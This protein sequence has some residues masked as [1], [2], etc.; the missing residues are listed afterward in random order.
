MPTIE[1]DTLNLESLSGTNPGD[2]LSARFRDLAPGDAFVLWTETDPEP[3]LRSLQA[4]ALDIV[5]WWPLERGPVTWRIHIAKVDA[6][7]AS[8]RTITNL[9]CADHQRLDRLYGRL[10]KALEAGDL[11]G[12]RG[13]LAEFE[14]GLLRHIAAEEDILMPLT[15]ERC[16]R[17]GVQDAAQLHAE[18]ERIQESFALAKAALG[19]TQFQESA[20][21]LTEMRFI[22]EGHNQNE[23]RTLYPMSDMETS[24]KERR[25]ILA[26]IQAV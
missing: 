17:R 6:G 12:A 9:L 13:L 18:H 23:E 25:E 5:E 11:E 1:L 16:G 22:L 10:Y 4:D 7:V 26:R 19:N 20:A 2:A 8:P 15:A 21:A 3:L 24:A 14:I